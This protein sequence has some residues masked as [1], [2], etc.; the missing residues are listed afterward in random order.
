MFDTEKSILRHIRTRQVYKNHFGER[1]RCR[2]GVV[3]FF[4]YDLS[5]ESKLDA[6]YDQDEGELATFFFKFEMSHSYIHV[7]F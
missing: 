4:V 6:M 2:F 1:S 3:F 5:S 7:M